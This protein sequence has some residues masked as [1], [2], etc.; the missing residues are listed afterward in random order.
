[1]QHQFTGISISPLSV[2]EVD[3]KKTDVELRTSTIHKIIEYDVNRVIMEVAKIIFHIFTECDFCKMYLK[4]CSLPS[5]EKKK[6]ELK[7]GRMELNSLKNS[8]DIRL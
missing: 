8:I 6:S 5:L 3:R 7:T 4:Y 2:K 1:M